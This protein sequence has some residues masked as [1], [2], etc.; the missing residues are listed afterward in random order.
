MNDGFVQGLLHDVGRDADPPLQAAFG[1]MALTVRGEPA[2]QGSKHFYG[3]GRFKEASAKVRPWRDEIVKEVMRRGLHRERIE[4]PM[5][6]RVTF[7]FER[8]SSHFGRKNR[9]PYLKPNTPLYYDRTPDIDKLCRSTLDGLT[10]SG[11]I[12]DDRHVVVLHAQ[13]RYDDWSGAMIV[14]EPVT[15]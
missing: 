10:D 9:V 11:L 14:I 3:K 15:P 2:P 12:E 5:S 6:V 1:V 8:P 4:G 13:K 7:V